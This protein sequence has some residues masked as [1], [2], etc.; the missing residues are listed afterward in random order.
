M[1]HFHI[2]SVYFIFFTLNPRIA[3]FLQLGRL[4]PLNIAFIGNVPF[5]LNYTENG[6]PQWNNYPEMLIDTLPLRINGLIPGP[7]EMFVTDLLFSKA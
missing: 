6:V 3:V 5:Q 7:V 2:Y 4:Q 1:R